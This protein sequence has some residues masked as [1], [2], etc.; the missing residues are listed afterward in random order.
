MDNRSSRAAGPEGFHPRPVAPNRSPPRRAGRPGLAAAKA[1]LAIVSLLV[2]SVTGYAWGNLRS[3]THGLST[4]DVID[5][6]LGGTKP[7]DGSVDILL[8]GLDSRTDA[9]GHPLPKAILSQ[10]HA[11]DD[12]GVSNT[13][14]MILLHIPVDGKEAMAMSL[15]RDSDVAI[16]GY[17]K[18]KLNS[19][20]VYAKNDALTTMRKQGVT[21]Q[22][23]L[24]ND[25]NQ[26]GRKELIEAVHDLTGVGV[27]HYAEVNLA[28]FYQI[29][30]A[31]GGVDVCLKKAVQDDYSGA[32]F[33]A[34][35]QSIQGA[36]AL[37]FVRQRH[38]LPGGD[39]DRVV[40]QQVFM[41][42][43]AHK[44]LS[45]GTLAD[46]GK[47]SAL[48]DAITKSV[49]L[50]Q[51]WDVLG[52]AQ[53]M[54]GLS[55]GNIKFKTM[56]TQGPGRSPTDG[57]TIVVDPAEVKQ[58]VQ[59]FNGGPD[60]PAGGTPSGTTSATQS[61]PTTSATV[62][63]LNATGTS[64]LANRVQDALAAEGYAKGDVGN[65]APR[66]T[67]VVRYA[68][69]S[70]SAGKAVAKSLGGL[71]AQPDSNVMSGHVEVVLGKAYHGPGSTGSHLG[72]GHV[73]QLDGK[74]SGSSEQPTSSGAPT[75]N[76]DPAI[77]A[78]GVTCI[79]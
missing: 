60:K 45:A 57:D 5:G 63:V 65:S 19:A 70:A 34:G 42:G 12:Q 53:Q 4:T 31:V 6:A 48:I 9:Q 29:S 33:R 54:Q 24:E 37:S 30:N 67:S 38:G 7:L 62:D 41:A 20:Y 66:S 18:H 36:A 10:L 39:L 44:I 40:R 8:V 16:P 15:P 46:P 35:P 49:I 11:G 73:V 69:D 71:D 23:K 75:T 72:G 28:S 59:N 2:L 22:V 74:P 26:A 32:N 56:P 25:S 79:N 76:G 77:T 52:F 1:L 64:G 58:F 27:D 55:G 50:D 78:D 68:S 43:M 3:L 51:G 47:L 21:D 61:D 17:G 13:D 14:T